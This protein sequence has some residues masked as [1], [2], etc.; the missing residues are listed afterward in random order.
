MKN[1]AIQLGNRA[2]GKIID[3]SP[4]QLNM[5]IPL[6][7]IPEMAKRALRSI[8]PG[9]S[10]I[11]MKDVYRNK[12]LY[13]IT[14]L[15]IGRD[16]K[17]RYELDD[18]M[19]KIKVDSID[20]NIESIPLTE[21]IDAPGLFSRFPKLEGSKIFPLEHPDVL[22]AVSKEG[23]IRINTKANAEWIKSIVV[24][25]I[26]HFI[27][28]ETGAFEGSNI[29]TESTKVMVNRLQSIIE[30]IKDERSKITLGNVRDRLERTKNMEA[31]YTDV[32]PLLEKN[33]NILGLSDDNIKALSFPTGG[34]VMYKVIPGEM[35]ARLSSYRRHLTASE[36]RIE[37]PWVSLDKML[38]EEGIM[39]QHGVRLYSGI[40]LEVI[41]AGA[42]KVAE[43]TAKARGL[44]Q[45]KL[46]HAAKMLREEF[47]RSFI[48]RSGNI[49]TELL[50][51]LGDEGYR[52]LQ[53]MV[54]E[55]GSSSRAALM[56][57]Q[58]RDEIYNGL[59]SQEKKI[60][61]DII[62]DD[63]M[64]DIG[65]YKN[66]SE[67]KHP[68]GLKLNDFIAHRELF[69]QL[70][71]LTPEVA[72][73]LSRRA[74]GYFE[75]MK[76]PLKDMLESGLISKEEY[77]NLSSHNYRRIKLVEIFDKRYTTKIGKKAMT[78]YDSGVEALQRGRDTDIYEPSSE[79]MALEVFNRAY[80]MILRNEAN[81]T[82]LD[83]KAKDPLNDFVRAK[84]KDGEKIPSGWSRIF[85]F[86]KGERKSL[87]ISPEM[88]KEWIY[89]S[90]EMSYR[91][92][93]IIR[94][95][96]GSVVTRTFA[97]GI[98]W[99]FALANLP[100]DMMHMWFAAR[101]FENGKW[102]PLYNHNLP[103][104]G[105]QIGRDLATV[106][107]DAS[108]RRGR[109]NDYFNEG[110]G[111]EFLVHQGR[112]FQRGRHLESGFDKVMN[113]L[114]YLGETSEI[115]TRLAIRER[116]L[117]KGKSAQEA[118]FTARD[119]MDFGQGGGVS[120]A[121]DNGLPYLNAA[122]QGSRGLLRSFKPGSGSALSST[123]KLG[124]LAAA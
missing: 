81:K 87:Y 119:Y 116:A 3:L 15:W 58:M 9:M 56:L 91:M 61:D 120:K 65:K 36:R 21:V 44:K 5:M 64:I 100:R 63:R 38:T 37:P 121:L 123:Y 46:G 97:T 39:P 69:P 30:G 90:P 27:N 28:Q 23:N 31:F 112:L 13:D 41:V 75:W 51:K 103:I 42:R 71:K 76:R 94:W 10:K 92:S 111:M 74:A 108:L 34:K 18:S 48:D 8:Y 101:T 33:K 25:E 113:F 43:Y 102:K 124:Q 45:I 96:S 82:L 88:S 83:L 78:V 57:K 67:F 53:G 107:T 11:S 40:P 98:E 110:G 84:T 7:K 72:A 106:F 89:S 19:M 80:G 60:L 49:R 68:K 85:V 4:N 1:R 29:A 52:I 118:T 50:D 117:R 109:Y 32:V 79:I 73:D 77:D 16:N 35:E 62:L 22:G 122:I 66:E 6:D 95:G 17:W 115:L 26:Q 14:G 70:E 24:H 47:S 93:Q 54:L 86:D 105:L 114:G 12:K 55:K 104:D 20:A 99:G 59:G 2:S